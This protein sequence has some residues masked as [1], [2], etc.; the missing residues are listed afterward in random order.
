MKEKI[1]EKKLE[2]AIKNK[3]ILI[4]EID[5]F[6]LEETDLKKI[7]RL[8]SENDV[9][10]IVEQEEKVLDDNY[11]DDSVKMYMREISRYPLLTPE[12][13]KSLF[14]LYKNGD[15]SAKEKIIQSNLRL[16][17]SIAKNYYQKNFNCFIKFLDMI[18]DGNMGL[19]KAVEKFDVTKGYKFS[20]YAT[21]WIRQSIL[22]QMDNCKRTIRI[23]VNKCAILKKIKKYSD[24]YYLKSGNIP[25]KEQLLDIFKISEEEFDML[26]LANN[27]V[28]SLDMKLKG[29][30][31]TTILE[32]ITDDKSISNSV[33][34]K[35]FSE[36]L[37]NELK[38]LLDERSYKILLLRNGFYND[39]VLTLEEIGQ[40]Y[41]ITKER[42]RQL[43]AKALKKAK[44]R[45]TKKYSLNDYM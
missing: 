18:Q 29:D 30:E 45:I 5:N 26:L 9:E 32:T 35:Y 23:P 15:K 10:I 4:E 11:T 19:M 1:I 28:N 42:V 43:E 12:E 20:T 34:N 25:T 38:S 36:E 13:E 16:S 2:E 33:E 17:A 24:E 14:I 21:L 22:R 6:N 37:K 39:E 44:P 40:I 27:E 31:E 8:L 41:G 7:Y 3:K